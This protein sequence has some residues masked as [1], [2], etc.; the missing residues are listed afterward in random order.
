MYIFG[1]IG[2]LFTYFALLR[3]PWICSSTPGISE[4]WHQGT[5]T[6]CKVFKKTFTKQIVFQRHRM[7]IPTARTSTL[8]VS[9]VEIYFANNARITYTTLKSRD[10]TLC[11]F[12]PT[13]FTVPLIPRS[14]SEVH[15]SSV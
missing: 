6:Q 10:Q 12:G 11:G 5:R 3:F 15:G 2:P 1:F 7:Y 4:P 8:G 13:K 14:E 9:N